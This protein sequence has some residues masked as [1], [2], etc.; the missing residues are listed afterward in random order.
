M[1]LGFLL[2]K[3]RWPVIEQRSQDTVSLNGTTKVNIVSFLKCQ[4][5]SYA[6]LIIT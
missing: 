4:E 3:V 6:L 1:K 2:K 5:R